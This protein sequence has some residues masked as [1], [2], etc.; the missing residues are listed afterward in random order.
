MKQ[1]ICLY[2]ITNIDTLP[3]TD[4]EVAT[5]TKNYWVPLMK[6]GSSTFINNVNTQPLALT[7]DDLVLP[8]TVNYK[9]LEN[10]YVCSPY[11]HYITYSQEEL[12][13]LNNPLLEK[14]LAQVLTFMGIILQWG[15]INQVVIV[16]NWLLST[17][18]YPD[19]STEQIQEITSYLQKQFP[20]HTIIFRS[21]NT[22]LSD[23]LFNS[24]VQNGYQMVGS[25]QIYLFNPKDTSVMRTKMRW[26]LKQDTELIQQ[27]GYEVI[28]SSQVSPAD[29]PRI[30]ELYNALYLEKYSYNN[31]QFNEK[32]IELALKNK[33]L[34][35]QALR[36]EE[37]IDGV[38][39]FY[40]LNGVMTT[41]LLGYDTS[42]PQNIG[43]YRMLSALLTIAATEKDII[44]HQSSG[45]AS[46]KRFRGFVANIEYSAIFY[47][48]LPAKRRLVWQVLR[49][50]VNQ[51]AVPLMRKY[52]L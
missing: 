4:S 9:E 43:L 14:S 37:K 36:K 47:Q 7:I 24:F 42:L 27:Q 49:L 6:A 45:A 15:E 22:F 8:V 35:I 38:I 31:P 11:S 32:L 44:L 10:S 34:Q 52:K 23:D 19:L 16:N 50:L 30:V 33:A 25:R 1:R 51:I 29:I 28:D 18:L 17:N 40:E 48:H 12:P 26:R 13:I 5:L 20:N 3:W 2:N 39:G 21:I 46:F 41:P